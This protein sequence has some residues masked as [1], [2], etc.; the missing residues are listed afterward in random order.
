MTVSSR[1]SS[2][3]RRWTGAMADVLAAAQRVLADAVL[4]LRSVHPALTFRGTDRI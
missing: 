4:P 2:R 1:T 3:F